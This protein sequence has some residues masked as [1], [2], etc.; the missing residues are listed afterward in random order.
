M[1]TTQTIR[2]SK[3]ALFTVSCRLMMQLCAKVGGEPWSIT[4]LP[5]FTRPTAVVGVH[6]GKDSASVVCSLN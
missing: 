1:I 2:E 3:H 4:E 5:Y 6:V